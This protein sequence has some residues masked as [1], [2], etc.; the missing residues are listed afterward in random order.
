M[1]ELSANVGQQ[2]T[3][4]NQFL[5]EMKKFDE[6]QSEIDTAMERIANLSTSCCELEDKLV[7]LEDLYGEMQQC[8]SKFEHE[9][10]LSKY[11][12]RK[13]MELEQVKGRSVLMSTDC[14]HTDAVQSFAIL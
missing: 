11:R 2:V 12:E 7:L 6:I 13:H 3:K 8:N 10:Q 9:Y 4:I 1:A 14:F 5:S